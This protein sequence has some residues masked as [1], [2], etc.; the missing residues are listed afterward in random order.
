MLAVPYDL[1]CYWTVHGVPTKPLINLIGLVHEELRRVGLDASKSAL[2]SIATKE[3]KLI[4][5]V[6]SGVEWN[7][8][9]CIH[10]L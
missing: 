3:Y 5:T 2:D 8:K 9:M 7:S 10:V 4:S 6:R 1:M